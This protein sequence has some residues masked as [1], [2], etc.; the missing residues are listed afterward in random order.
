MLK[1]TKDLPSKSQS[2]EVGFMPQYISS[3]PD[4]CLFGVLERDFNLVRRVA[5]ESLPE[6]EIFSDM[7]KLVE[8]D[9]TEG[10]DSNILLTMC[11]A[12]SA[13]PVGAFDAVRKR[14]LNIVETDAF[15]NIAQTILSPEF[16]SHLNSE[17][18]S[19]SRTRAENFLKALVK[20][21]ETDP[22]SFDGCRWFGGGQLTKEQQENV[23]AIKRKLGDALDRVDENWD[24]LFELDPRLAKIVEW[25]GEK[26]KEEMLPGAKL[27]GADLKLYLNEI[28]RVAEGN[29]VTYCSMRQAAN[30]IARTL[31]DGDE[32][33]MSSFKDLFLQLME[34][35]GTERGLR[36]FGGAKLSEVDMARIERVPLLIEKALDRLDPRWPLK[37][38]LDPVVRTLLEGEE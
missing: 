13:G 27:D 14:V 11:N 10:T 26:G 20:L 16:L 37:P 21:T 3:S 28:R 24:S 25:F 1:P 31:Y 6:L 30:V 33:V 34:K 7:C 5:E 35:E 9:V 23:K 36:W 29:A 32:A 15:N 19:H 18:G 2:L 17:E 22:E 12:A 8:R 38:E 4:E